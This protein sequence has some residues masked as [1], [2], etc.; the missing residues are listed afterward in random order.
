MNFELKVSMQTSFLI[1]CYSFY[2][3]VFVIKTTL[4]SAIKWIGFVGITDLITEVDFQYGFET[5]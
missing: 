5:D 4:T 3:L 2:I 1:A